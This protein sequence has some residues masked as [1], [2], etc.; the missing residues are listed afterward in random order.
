MHTMYVL[1]MSCICVT[2]RSGAQHQ[3]TPDVALKVGRVVVSG[4]I[5]A[6]KVSTLGVCCSS[7]AWEC[8]VAGKIVG[9]LVRCV[10]AFQCMLTVILLHW[11]CDYHGHW[12]SPQLHQSRGGAIKHWHELAVPELHNMHHSGPIAGWVIACLKSLGSCIGSG[13]LQPCYSCGNALQTV[14][15][16]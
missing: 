5:C 9:V 8:A 1:R 10:S 11:S 6:R 15:A 3:N 12:V 7:R 16:D 4:Y 13:M 2:L 14:H